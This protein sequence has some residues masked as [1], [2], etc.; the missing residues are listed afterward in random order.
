M[1][2]RAPFTF[3]RLPHITH[4]RSLASERRAF[5]RLFDRVVDRHTRLGLGAL[6]QGLYDR[7]AAFIY[8]GAHRAH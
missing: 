5:A 2:C 4:Y 6:E 8:A 3:S 1:P 7:S